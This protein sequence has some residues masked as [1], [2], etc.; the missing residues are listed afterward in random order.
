MSLYFKIL[1]GAFILPFLLS[2]DKKVAF[3]KSWKYLVPSIA[4]AMA[5]FIPWDIYFTWRNVWG[6]TDE[7]LSGIKLWHL[8]LEEWLFFVV[9]PYASVFTFD[10]VKAYFPGLADQ[11]F[12]RY[13]G[14]F[15]ILLSTG[16]ILFFYD[17][18]Y[19][20][21]AFGLTLLLVLLHHILLKTSWLNEFYVAYLLILLP[22]FVVNG[23]LT[24][25]GIPEQVVW[26]S[27]SGMIGW[28]AITIP[29]ED[30]FYSFSLILLNLG[31]YNYFR[32]RAIW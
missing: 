9:I 5:V 3:Y 16:M 25:Y 18:I 31:F 12:H 23:L 20:V 26:Y 10:V 13:A 6:F 15:F 1:L 14:L 7:Y 2:F 21:T 32:G 29:F 30:F 17:G 27:P 28:R 19:T 4:L 11:K 8:P 22:F 24:G